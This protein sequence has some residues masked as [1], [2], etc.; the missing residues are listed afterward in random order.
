MGQNS[1]HKG[2]QHAH[3]VMIYLIV[4]DIVAVTLSYFVA[5]ASGAFV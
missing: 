3:I 1:E 4:Y 5:S 2:L